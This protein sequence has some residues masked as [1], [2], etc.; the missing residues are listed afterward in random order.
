M[1]EQFIEPTPASR[2]RLLVLVAVGIAAGAAL[3]FWLLPTFFAF[4]NGLPLCERFRWLQGLLASA[5][6]AMPLFGLWA[7]WHA[8]R[9]LKARQWPLPKAPVWRRTRVLTGR[10][11][12]WRAYALLA[13]ACLA[14]SVPVLGAHFLSRAGLLAEP[15]QCA[16]G[17]HD[18]AR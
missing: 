13:W 17:T 10:S 16:S 18:P 2:R 4:V 5:L 1:E 7:A 15:R 8:R 12:A 11:V 6:G 14:V 3:Q 9:L